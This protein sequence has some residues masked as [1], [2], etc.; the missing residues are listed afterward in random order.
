MGALGVGMQAVLIDRS[1]YGPDAV[2]C[3]KIASLSELSEI[4][5]GLR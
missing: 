3:P 2:D 5:E 1:G 4:L